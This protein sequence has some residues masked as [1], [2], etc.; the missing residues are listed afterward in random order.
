M[1]VSAAEQHCAEGLVQ[2]ATAVA[3]AD[4]LHD[5]KEVHEGVIGACS[6]IRHP[7]SDLPDLLEDA[8]PEPPIERVSPSPLT[9]T[10]MKQQCQPLATTGACK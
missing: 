1:Q 8:L 7:W 3:A 6:S 9:P 4:G 5:S 10:D 2:W